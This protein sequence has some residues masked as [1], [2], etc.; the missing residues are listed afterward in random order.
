MKPGDTPPKFEETMYYP[1]PKASIDRCQEILGKRK[2]TKSEEQ[3]TGREKE[4][5]AKEDKEDEEDEEKDE[6]VK[7]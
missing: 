5:G 4:T 7:K 6:G 3:D 2:D 1:S